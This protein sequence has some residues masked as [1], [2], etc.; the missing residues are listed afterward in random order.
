MPCD[1]VGE[2]DFQRSYDG[3]VQTHW[4]LVSGGNIGIY[5]LKCI[6]T[7]TLN[8]SSTL[9]SDIESG[10]QILG[11]NEIARIFVAVFE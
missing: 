7:S 2:A 8:E 5:K 4:L 1:G 9:L 6:E 3:V 11:T 10:S